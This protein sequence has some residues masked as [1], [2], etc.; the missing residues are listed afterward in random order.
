MALLVNEL[1]KIGIDGRVLSKAGGKMV[2]LA[3]GCI[4]CQVSEDMISTLVSLAD[5]QKPD[6]IL[7]ES[8]GVAE[9]GKILGMLY[10][11]EPLVQRMRVEPT[12]IVV[13]AGAFDRF[14]KELAYHYVMQIKSADVILLNK[15][16]LVDKK[17]IARVEKEIQEL[18]PRAFIRK[19]DHCRINLLGLLEGIPAS[20]GAGDSDEN[21]DHDHS[22]DEFESF[23]VSESGSYDRKKLETFLSKLPAGVFR[24][25]GFVKTKDGTY[26]VNFT[27]GEIEL[28]A[29]SAA[30]FPGK[31]QLVFIGRRLEEKKLRAALKRCKSR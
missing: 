8:T 17:T 21:H 20:A 18:N 23:S 24:S 6:R 31:N 28:E 2:E 13:D 14:K 7:I 11:A 12:V 25:K 29:V 30:E 26:L 5:E 9:P 3:N 16:D 1:G 27:A 10:T 4:C 15:I 22:A 19:T